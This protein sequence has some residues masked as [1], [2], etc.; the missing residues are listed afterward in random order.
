[1]PFATQKLRVWWECDSY[2]E[3]LFY[4]KYII[5]HHNDNKR[6]EYHAALSPYTGDKLKYSA[7]NVSADIVGLAAAKPSKGKADGCDGVTTDP[8]LGC[9]PIIFS[10]LANNF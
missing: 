4:I 1:M 2:K 7:F 10:I 3:C 9:H 8:I 5:I 6:K